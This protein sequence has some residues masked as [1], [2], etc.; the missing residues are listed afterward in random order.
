MTA[1]LALDADGNFL[2][3]RLTGFGNMGAFLATVAP[4]PVDA[5]TR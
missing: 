2:A 1:E 3:V 5:A 4:M